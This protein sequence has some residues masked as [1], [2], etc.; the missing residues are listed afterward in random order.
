MNITR[1]TIIDLCV[2][3]LKEFGYENVNKENIFTDEIYKLFFKRQLQ[4]ALEQIEDL[5][6][7][8]IVNNLLNEIC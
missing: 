6:T 1:E 4:D 2:K 7:K 5:R 3:S 8:E